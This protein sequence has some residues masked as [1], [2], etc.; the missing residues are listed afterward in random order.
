MAQDNS[1]FVVPMMPQE[2]RTVLLLF[3]TVKLDREEN[4]SLCVV[5]GVMA[6]MISGLASDEQFFEIKDAL[7]KL[8][9]A[10]GP[11]AQDVKWFSDGDVAAALEYIEEK[12]EAL[13]SRRR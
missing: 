7:R 12:K 2:T 5:S 13:S 4:Y 6:R 1:L 11:R 3:V 9:G 10:R 8:R